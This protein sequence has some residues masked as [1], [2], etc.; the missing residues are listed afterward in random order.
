[1]NGPIVLVPYTV[2]IKL[3][4]PCSETACSD[5]WSNDSGGTVRLPIVISLYSPLCYMATPPNP[6]ISDT[7]GI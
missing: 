4:L 7:S 2:S 3:V 5:S 1:M 6:L